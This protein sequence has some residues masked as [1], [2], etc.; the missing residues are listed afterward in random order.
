M[1]PGQ[2]VLFLQKPDLFSAVNRRLQSPELDVE[3]LFPEKTN[4]SPRVSAFAPHNLPSPR[5][6][7]LGIGV[8][9]EVSSPPRVG[10]LW[11]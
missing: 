6:R 2:E 8:G 3:V 11:A 7:P 5:G 4:F 10:A 1:H 9:G